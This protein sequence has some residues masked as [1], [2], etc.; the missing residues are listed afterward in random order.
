MT[1]HLFFKNDYPKI[2][3]SA[4]ARVV[5]YCVRLPSANGHASSPRPSFSLSRRRFLSFFFFFFSANTARHIRVC[6]P[7]PRV[8]KSEL[9]RAKRELSGKR[10]NV[11]L[12]REMQKENASLARPGRSLPGWPSRIQRAALQ[13]VADLFSRARGLFLSVA[14]FLRFF[15]FSRPTEHASVLKKTRCVFRWWRSRTTHSAIGAT[16]GSSFYPKGDACVFDCAST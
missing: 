3:V 2:E 16:G 4:A 5:C 6:Y 9:S 8:P 15:F 10:S 13:P 12:A 7:F 14:S 1:R 11:Q